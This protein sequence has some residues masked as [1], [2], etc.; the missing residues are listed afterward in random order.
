MNRASSLIDD[1]ES[2]IIKNKSSVRR[3]SKG[4]KTKEKILL[5]T[6]D[7]L[8][9]KGIKGTTHRAI[10][11][12][13]ELQLS[14]TTYYFKDI[15]EL[16]QEAFTLNCQNTSTNSHHLLAPIFSIIE[17][18]EKKD[19][20]KV[21]IKEALCAELS[22]VLGLHL[23]NRVNK[24]STELLVEQFLFS[25]TKVSPALIPLAQKHQ[26]GL[27]LP[28]EQFCQYFN[29]VDPELDA[30]IMFTFISQLQYK[31]LINIESLSIEDIY[32]PIRKLLAWIMKVK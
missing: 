12:Q 18:V 11:A 6:I 30:Q 2:N 29:K 26:I 21:A 14:L 5:A 3:R 25:E 32:K 16:I 17:N 10:A 15:Q 31:S 20:R 13:A 23:I 27:V 9:T 4:E 7:V 28:F 19:L 8:A 22:E 24:Q 1:V